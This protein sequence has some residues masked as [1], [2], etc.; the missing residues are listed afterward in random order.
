MV[1]A[2]VPS[3]RVGGTSDQWVFSAVTD[4]VSVNQGKESD[5][6]TTDT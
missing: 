3:E 1:I 2:K 5:E 4:P 6:D